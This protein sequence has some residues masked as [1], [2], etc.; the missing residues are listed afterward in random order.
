M[1]KYERKIY[2]INEENYYVK[3][4]TWQVYKKNCTSKEYYKN[5]VAVKG[6]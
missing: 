6:I 4:I 1:K 3:K 5:K 2:Y